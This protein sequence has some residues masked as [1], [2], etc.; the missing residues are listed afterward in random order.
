MTHCGPRATSSLGLFC[1]HSSTG[2]Q[3]APVIYVLPLTAFKLQGGAGG[4]NQDGMAHRAYNVYYL[5]LYK[6]VCQSLI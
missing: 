3:P 6:K 2:T 5:A 1:K 4:C